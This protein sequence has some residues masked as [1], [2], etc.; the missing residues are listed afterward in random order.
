MIAV[1]VV[2]NAFEETYEVYTRRWWSGWRFQKQ[3]RYD[4]PGSSTQHYRS[5]E[6]AKFHAI[7]YA[8][9]LLSKQVVFKSSNF[10]Y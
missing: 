6:E 2:H 1:K 7:T 9:S 3:Y 8:K 10:F 5:Q 4:G